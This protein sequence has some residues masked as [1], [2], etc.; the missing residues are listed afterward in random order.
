[1][2]PKSIHTFGL[3]HL[4][5]SGSDDVIVVQL[6][7]RQNKR[8][9]LGV[10]EVLQVK[11]LHCSSV[12]V[13]QDL[14]SRVNPLSQLNNLLLFKNYHQFTGNILL[15]HQLRPIFG[16]DEGECNDPLLGKLL[17]LLSR[18]VDSLDFGS[19]PKCHSANSELIEK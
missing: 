5:E 17:H 8:W 2:S 14:A 11:N 3:Q 7:Q 19:C 4:V 1:M 15:P 13:R 12:S 6:I 16:Q 9:K 18:L 10:E